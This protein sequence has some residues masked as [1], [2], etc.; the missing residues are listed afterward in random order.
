MQN[1]ESGARASRWGHETARAIA[2][3]LGASDI[4]RASNECR[5]N[6]ERI[7]IKCAAVK[8]RSVGVTYKMLERVDRIVGAFQRHDRLF[9]LWAMTPEQFR[10]TM[11]ATQSRGTSAG[12]V[13]VVE[14][15]IFEQVGTKLGRVNVER[16]G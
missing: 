4:R 5:L 15:R 10:A 3:E 1:R 8:T 12:K 2:A 16:A 7:V 13:A 6:N 9:E 14:R 11:R